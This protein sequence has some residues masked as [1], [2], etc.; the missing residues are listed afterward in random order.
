M[1][2]QQSS[3]WWIEDL[4]EDCVQFQLDLS[5]LVDKELDEVAAVRS[6]AHLED[7]AVCRD[8]FD[9]IREQVRAHNELSDTDGLVARYSAL[10]GSGLDGEVEAIEL[11]DKLSSVFYQL[12]KAYVLIEFE[13]GWRTRVVI[14][15]TVQVEATKN[16]GRGYVDAVMQSGRSHAAGLDL[17]HARALLNGR[18][19]KIEDPLEKGRRLLEEALAVDPCHE[20]ARFYLAYLHAHAGKKVRA[21]QEFRQLFRSAV[22]ETNRAHAAVQLGHLHADEGEYGKALACCRWVTMSGLADADEEDRFYYVRF[23][24]GMYYA[25]LRKPERSLAAFR[26]LLDRHPGRLQDVSR[27]FLR[28]PLLR[29]VIDR[30]PG[31]AEALVGTCPELFG[32]SD[33]EPDQGSHP[34]GAEEAQS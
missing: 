11:V 34:G 33:S 1:T 14:E 24:I 8:F 12:G 7:C 4:T 30:Q 23:N 13:P 32:G 9:D 2:S 19:E 27:L 25:H 3:P 17:G 6:I 18:L 10:V 29:A 26:E 16:R 20:E 31:F 5:C 21:S 28:S 22:D 15:E